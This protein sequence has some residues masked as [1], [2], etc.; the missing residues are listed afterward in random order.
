MLFDC[1]HLKEHERVFPQFLVSPRTIIAVAIGLL[2]TNEERAKIKID[3]NDKKD[4]LFYISLASR[5]QTFMWLVV[6]LIS[7]YLIA[8]IFFSFKEGNRTHQLKLTFYGII[9]GVLLL[10]YLVCERFQN[11]NS[12]LFMIQYS[13]INLFSILMAYFH[14]PCESKEKDTIEQIN[15]VSFSLK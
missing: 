7:F 11:R 8:V 14:W 4:V 10:A 13:I 5:I 2:K 9:V 15:Y 12:L 1:F 6:L 3:R